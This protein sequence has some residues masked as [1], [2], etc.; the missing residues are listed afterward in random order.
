MCTRVRQATVDAVGP[1]PILIHKPLLKQ[2]ARPWWDMSKRMQKDRD[3][4]VIFGWVRVP[5]V[6]LPT[7]GECPTI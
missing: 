1:S 6:P 3:A 7:R 2:V 5:R 4:Q